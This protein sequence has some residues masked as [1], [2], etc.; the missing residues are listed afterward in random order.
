[1]AAKHSSRTHKRAAARPKSEERIVVT[2][3]SNPLAFDEKA[4]A[5]VQNTVHALYVIRRLAIRALAEPT[6]DG[7]GDAATFC[8]AIK[9]MA[10]LHGKDLDQCVG[11]V[12]GSSAGC[13][14]EA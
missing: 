6:A 3:H 13:F 11:R 10:L 5:V 14:D 4:R 8:Y 12:T 2:D 7:S 1:M 9:Q